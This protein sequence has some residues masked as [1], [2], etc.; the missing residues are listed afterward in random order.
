MATFVSKYGNLKLVMKPTSQTIV[1]NQI[2]IEH[3]KSVEFSNGS[4]HTKNPDEIHFL[5]NH[6]AKGRMFYEIDEKDYYKEDET[7]QEEKSSKKKTKG[8][9]ATS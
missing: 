3:G 8:A 1:N 6:D 5:R 7:V 9:K 2:I 4:F